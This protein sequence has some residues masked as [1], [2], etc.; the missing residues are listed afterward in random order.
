MDDI[1]SAKYCPK[2]EG[3]WKKKI[4]HDDLPPQVEKG[5]LANKIIISLYSLSHLY[6]YIYMRN[7]MK[8]QRVIPFP[9]SYF[10]STFK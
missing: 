8:Q 9:F 6:I 5:V 4:R 10:P 3:N 7:E 1:P 2:E